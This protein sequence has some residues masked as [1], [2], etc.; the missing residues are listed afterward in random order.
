MQEVMKGE[1][2]ALS[3]L[4]KLE[5]PFSVD[6]KG[7]AVPEQWNESIQQHIKDGKILTGEDVK[8]WV[9]YL[10]APLLAP[11]NQALIDLGKTLSRAAAPQTAGKRAQMALHQA[12]AN[13]VERKEH[14]ARVEGGESPILHN[15]SVSDALRP[16][17]QTTRL[18][19]MSDAQK[20]QVKQ[21]HDHYQRVVPHQKSQF[22]SH[23]E[24]RIKV[25]A[26]TASVEALCRSYELLPVS[27]HWVREKGILNNDAWKTCEGFTD[28]NKRYMVN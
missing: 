7:V 10:Q 17:A 27:E 11:L 24:E 15:P 1:A 26:D 4:S 2:E 3:R 16:L 5:K 18:A 21:L 14:A 13:Q 23:R 22:A 9:Q 19:P 12:A 6:I 8:R 28:F 20:V 25:L